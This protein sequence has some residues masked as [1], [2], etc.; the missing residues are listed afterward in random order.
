MYLRTTTRQAPS[1]PVRYLYLAHNEWDP[2][3]GRSVAHTLKSLGRED[4]VDRRA[5]LERLV[6]SL[7]TFLGVDTARREPGEVAQVVE[8]RPAGGAWVLDGVWKQLGLDRVILEAPARGRGRP[9]D[10]EAVERVVFSLVANRAL[11]PSS[12][13]A[14]VEWMR[15]DVA[16]AGLDAA[17]VDEDACYRAMDYLV[18]WGGQAGSTRLRPGHGPPQLGGRPVVLRHDLHLLRDPL[19]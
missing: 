14:A 12:K 2:V 11:A 6:A 8:S 5:G 18:E 16:I 3:R 19:R 15:H 17:G 1:G 13:L 9:R 4:E 7:Q 10:M